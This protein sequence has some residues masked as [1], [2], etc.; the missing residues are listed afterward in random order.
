MTTYKVLRKAPDGEL[1]EMLNEGIETNGPQQAI[2][3]VAE[4]GEVSWGGDTYVAV[5]ASN[6][7]EMPISLF[8]PPAR[9][10]IGVPP[11]QI[12]VDEATEEQERVEIK[13][14]A[15]DT[16]AAANESGS[17]QPLTVAQP[18]QDT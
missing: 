13:A 4:G 7:S 17:A 8:R 1:Y 2:K 9:L 15:A 6:W 3:Q 5:P 11:E 16:L 18:G 12:S 10:R 14:L